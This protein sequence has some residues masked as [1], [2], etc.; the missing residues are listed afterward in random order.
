MDADRAQQTVERAV[1]DVAPDADLSVLDP[2]GDLRVQLD[3]DSMDFL[4]L[5]QR[6]H[7]LTG[8]ALDEDD[9][10]R[11]GT[12]SSAVRLLVDRTAVPQA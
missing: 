12:L 5:V 2:E 6:L 1:T 3:L 7:D 4:T 9:Y 10:G 11:L 8:V